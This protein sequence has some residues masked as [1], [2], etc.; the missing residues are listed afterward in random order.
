MIRDLQELGLHLDRIRE[1]IG[2]RQAGEAREKF[3][4]RVRQALEEQDRM[5]VERVRTLEAQRTKVAQALHKI[6]E[7]RPLHAHRPAPPT[8]S[9][10][11]ARPRARSCLNT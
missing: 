3:L 1:L 2:A 7:C 9:A 8:T 10:S 6:S 11:P 5:L 4:D